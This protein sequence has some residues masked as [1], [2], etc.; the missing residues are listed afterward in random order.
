LEKS[1]I[2]LNVTCQARLSWDIQGVQK[3]SLGPAM[4]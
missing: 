1:A 3:V 4:P 2:D